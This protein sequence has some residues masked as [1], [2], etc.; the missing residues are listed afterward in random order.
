MAIVS[1]RKFMDDVAQVRQVDISGMK[2][3]FRRNLQRVGLGAAPVEVPRDVMDFIRSRN[4]RV[5]LDV[6]ANVGQFG[7]TMRA[8]G[9]RG[10]IVSFEPI[11]AV[12]RV[13]AAKAAAD[14]NWQ[15]NNFAL[16]AKAQRTTIH[17]SR[18]S[19]YSSILRSTDAATRFDDDAV[20]KRDETIEVRTLD[21]ICPDLSEPT[22]LKIDT[23]GYE[24]QVLEGARRVL[25]GMAAVL[26][27]LPIIHLYEGNWQF[28]EAV[29]FMAGVGF[30][31]AQ[32]HPVNYHSA[33]DVSLVEVDCLF[34]P[35]D[36][37]LDAGPN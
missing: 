35:R 6:G 21:D 19:V 5:I 11:S 14:G 34:R 3:F 4:I 16:G 31:P 9:Y 23:Q 10:K 36:E 25:P 13:L 27:E 17:V 37:R 22:L 8:K 18:L 30:V 7:E 20:V 15:A 33:D 2:R 28:H 29:A 32:I 26:M 24:Q 12:Y 1:A